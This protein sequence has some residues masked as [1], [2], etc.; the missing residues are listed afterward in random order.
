MLP[1]M[2]LRLTK[3]LKQYNADK[4]Q[5]HDDPNL[6]SDYLPWLSCLSFNA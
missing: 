4:V 5:I 6:R 1:G 2:I 3:E